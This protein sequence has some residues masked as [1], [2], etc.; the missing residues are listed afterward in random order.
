M[1]KNNIVSANVIYKVVGTLGRW[2]VGSGQGP[3]T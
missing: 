3:W 1:V 2:M